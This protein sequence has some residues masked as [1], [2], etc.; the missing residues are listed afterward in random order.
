MKLDTVVIGAGVIGLACARA[1]AQQGREV[2][3]LERGT[4]IGEQTSARNS[5][6][7]HAGLYYPT[8]SN[9]ARF[10]VQGRRQLDAYLERRNI[11]HKKCGKLIV[12]SGDEE[13]ARLGKL[14]Q[15]AA[16]NGVDGI[17]ALTGDEA[18]ALEPALSPRISAALHS[19]ET[20]IFDSHAFFLSL[21]AD[22]EAAGGSVAFRSE[23]VAGTVE[24]DSVNLTIR[25]DADHR[26]Q[27]ATVINAAGLQAVGLARAIRGAHAEA[28]P[29][30]YFAKGHYF[31]VTG[32]TPFAHLIY[33]LPNEAGLGTHL[34]LDLGGRGRLGPDVAW[35]P[36]GAAEPFD[37]SVPPDRAAGFHKAAQAFWPGLRLDQLQPD[38]SGIRPK[39]VG[40]GQA[41]GD[42]MIQRAAHG[43]LINL[44]GIESPGLTSALAI[45]EHVAHQTR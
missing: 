25:G 45:A 1:L 13:A 12:A 24:D 4:Q 43:R 22:F 6:I 28:L 14:Q 7:I 33:P 10:C 16:A 35:L 44:L 23:V 5:E 40:P 39:L 3:L 41:P 36:A 34:T 38:Y 42:F 2:V 32:T 37:Y 19:S 20:G 30:P 18:R 17:T 11:A 29:K 9:K 31:S 8:K 21:L 15:Q 27:A 26:V